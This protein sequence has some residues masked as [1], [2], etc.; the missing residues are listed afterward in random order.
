MLAPALRFFCVRAAARAAAAAARLR[1]R[2]FALVIKQTRGDGSKAQDQDLF[3]FYISVWTCG[4][5]EAG[6]EQQ[7][8]PKSLKA[9]VTRHKA[10]RVYVCCML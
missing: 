7:L 8:L 6:T 10:W 4:V 5:E 2:S 9:K 1:A 3:S